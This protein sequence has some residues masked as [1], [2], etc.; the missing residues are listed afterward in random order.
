[1]NN[2][3]FSRAPWL[4]LVLESRTHVTTL[5]PQALA[6]VVKDLNSAVASEEAQQAQ[7]ALISA[8]DSQD[9]ARSPHAAE[10]GLMQVLI[11]C[12]NL[13]LEEDVV[14][15]VVDFQGVLLGGFVGITMESSGRPAT[16]QSHHDT[17]G[18]ALHE[19]HEYAG[20]KAK[21]MSIMDIWSTVSKLATTLMRYKDYVSEMTVPD[22]D[23]NVIANLLT[24][25]TDLEAWT[26]AGTGPG[27]SAPANVRYPHEER[28]VTHIV[29][30][31]DDTR[32]VV[33]A[34]RSASRQTLVNKLSSARVRLD[35][36]AGGKDEGGS[37]KEGVAADADIN[38]MT[39][40]LRILETAYIDACQ[41][42]IDTVKEVIC[43]F[44]V[45][46]DETLMCLPDLSPGPSV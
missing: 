22:A 21:D 41:K 46:S 36:V 18:E 25:K 31:L 27:A 30:Y 45:C 34:K 42:R 5:L 12:R 40:A 23:E 7:A 44:H 4:D 20:V 10:L 24:C 39:E 2:F 35:K 1:M 28:L 43:K 11:R 8:M 29:R 9:V 16:W 13:T 15:R 33:T 17:V 38:S 14:R 26:Q 19:L 37:W 6:K 32:E 3:S